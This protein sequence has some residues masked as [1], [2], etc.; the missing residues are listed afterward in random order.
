MRQ[1]YASSLGAF[2][3]LIGVGGR[4]VIANGAPVALVFAIGLPAGTMS[5]AIYQSMVTG[6]ASNTGVSLKSTT[7]AGTEVSTGLVATGSIGI[8][9]DADRL[10]MAITPKASDLNTV[11]EALI[12][13][14]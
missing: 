8:Y 14:N 10:V 2:A 7:I 9:R 6:I 5:D 1:Q 12:T 11:A 4:T 13:A 3:G